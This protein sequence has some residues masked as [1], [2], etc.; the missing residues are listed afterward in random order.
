MPLTAVQKSRLSDASSSAV[1]GSARRLVPHLS[2]D[3]W[4]GKRNRYRALTIDAIE[5][6]DKA[7]TV[8]DRQL[9]EY[10]A[11]S[12]PLHCCDAWSYFGRAIG[13]HLHG[14]PNA[15]L[16]LAYYAELR[17]AMSLLGTQGIGIF[18]N[19]HFVI[20]QDG[21]VVRLCTNKR[22]HVATWEVLEAWANLPRAAELLG[23]VL[24]PGGRPMSEWV[25]AIP[26]GVSW[27]PLATDWL[28]T[29]GLDLRLLSKDREARNEASYRPMYLRQCASL[30]SMDAASVAEEMW[31]LLEP[32]PPLS[33]GQLDRHLLR[34]TLE[35]AVK[36]TQDTGFL[37]D[38]LKFSP[39]VQGM[40]NACVESDLRHLWTGFLERSTVS[41]EAD[42][43]RTITLARKVREVTD[44]DHH[45]AVMARALLLLRV[46]SGATRQLLMDSGIG[47]ERLGFWW[48]P[49]GVGRG[50][51]DVP[52]MASELTN[53]WA[54]FQ[55]A[56]EDLR[57]WLDR[58]VTS[59]TSYRNL[60]AD[61][62]QTMT[63]LTN[64]E[65][66]GLWSLAS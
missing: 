18:S 49:Y 25:S 58:G 54:D 47:F 65:L 1:V 15:A 3:R 39:L 4:L 32:A 9:A 29:M 26:G 38:P 12:A 60:L 20:K 7:H 57:G 45:V 40:V 61:V 42:D 36:S 46:A 59:D 16:H 41:G 51:W 27:Q 13:C 43:P 33:F 6:D 50:L 24:R 66:V 11:S 64:M 5:A 22:T 37:G 2:D 63:T 48:H 62:P 19:R 35:A 14:D 28:V 56:L 23:K 30:P 44:P 53:G 8:R 21:A 31:H 10:I 34:L 17:A 55:A 52:P